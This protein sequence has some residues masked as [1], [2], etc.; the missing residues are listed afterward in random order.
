[1]QFLRSENDVSSSGCSSA[2]SI[3]IGAGGSGAGVSGGSDGP[4]LFWA[5]G[6]VVGRG[7]L[8]G[9]SSGFFFLEPSLL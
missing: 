1:M 5:P 9:G 2:G 8:D 4:A 7:D 3:A 6:D